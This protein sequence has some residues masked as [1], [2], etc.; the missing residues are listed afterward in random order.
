MLKFV[1]KYN[2]SP[3]HLMLE[4]TERNFEIGIDFLSPL[5]A[6][7][8]MGFKISMDDFSVGHS[9]FALLNIFPFDEVKLDLGLL[10]KDENDVNQQVVYQ[11]I[12]NAVKT[13]DASLVAEGI[14]TSFHHHFL[15]NNGITK[16]QG[17][18]LSR[19]LPKEEFIK[20]LKKE[21]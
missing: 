17:Y 13:N 15:L 4:V 1:T 10:P 7:K 3:K 6:L 8:A 9:S 19:P 11:N 12:I 21:S 5:K 16:G 2:V 14:E 18:F 20:L